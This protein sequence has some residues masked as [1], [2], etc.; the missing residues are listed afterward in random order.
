MPISILA[1]VPTTLETLVVD[2]PVPLAVSPEQEWLVQFLELLVPEEV[3]VPC[4]LCLGLA[5]VEE[6]SSE[7][8]AGAGAGA[9]RRHGDISPSE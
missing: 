1:C 6:G 4:V 3:V 8:P 5:L 9:A 7:T 2:F